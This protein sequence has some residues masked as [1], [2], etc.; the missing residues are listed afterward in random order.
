MNPIK[1]IK[2]RTVVMPAKDIDTDQIIPARFLTT[3][4]KEGLGKVVFSELRRDADGNDIDT[5][6][7]NQTQSA[8]C[9]I[10]VAGN[11]F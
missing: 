10:L 3:T 11:N 1:I 8:G 7:L 2:S 9:R 4:T 5:F 6:V